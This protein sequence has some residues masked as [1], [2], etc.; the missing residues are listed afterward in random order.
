M[1]QVRF[2][3][4]TR[5]AFPRLVRVVGTALRVVDALGLL[6]LGLV[7]HALILSR[8]LVEESLLLALTERALLVLLRKI[9]GSTAARAQ[10]VFAAVTLEVVLGSH[11]TARH[12]RENE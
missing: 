12:H 5:E 8:L 11:V 6:R 2:S 9:A 7:V 1:K 10:A 4:T 3:A